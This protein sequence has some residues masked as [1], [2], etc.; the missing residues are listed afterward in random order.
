MLGALML[1]VVLAGCAPGATATISNSC[2]HSVDIYIDERSSAAVERNFDLDV[3]R[4]SWHVETL[5]GGATTEIGLRPSNLAK[6]VMVIVYGAD[7]AKVDYFGDNL[8]GSLDYA[9]SGGMCL[10]PAEEPAP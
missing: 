5:E 3:Y 7:T 9:I 2:T 6:T 8:T 4:E 1:S 10:L